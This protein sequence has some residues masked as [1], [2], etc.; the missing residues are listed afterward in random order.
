MSSPNEQRRFQVREIAE[1]QPFTDPAVRSFFHEWCK[2]NDSIRPKIVYRTEWENRKRR[3]T[4]LQRKPGG[5]HLL[6]LPDDLQLWEMIIIIETIDQNTFR[7]DPEKQNVATKEIETLG[8]MFRNAGIYIAQRLDAIENGQEIAEALAI[9]FYQYGRSLSDRKKPE[10]EAPLEEIASQTLSAEET[11]KV[12]RFLAGDSLYAARRKNVEKEVTIDPT[13]ADTLYE[14]VRRKTL[15]QFFRVSA[16]AFELNHRTIKESLKKRVM[17]AMKELRC[18]LTNLHQDPVGFLLSLDEESRLYMNEKTKNLAWEEYQS[19]YRKSDLT[20]QELARRAEL[21]QI[22]FPTKPWETPDS[23]H[24]SFLK[25][26]ER[27]IR[28]KVETPVRELDSSIF[29]RGLELIR[30][31]MPLNVAS[32]EKRGLSHRWRS[33]EKKLRKALQIE[34][35]ATELQEVRASGDI[36]RISNKE[37][38]ITDRI[39]S[40]V[41]KFPYEEASDAVTDIIVRQQMN[42]LGATILGGTLMREVGL[43]YLI[44]APPEHVLLLLLRSDG[45]VEWRDMVDTVHNATLTDDMLDGH[46]KEG[47]RLG[48]RDIVDFYMNPTPDG[49]IFRIKDDRC[50]KSISWVWEHGP[51]YFAVQGQEYGEQIH[52]LDNMGCEF[53]DLN[54]AEEALEILKRANALQPKEEGIYHN[55][56][57]Q[58]HDL[59]RTQESIEMCREGIRAIGQS[60]GLHELLGSNFYELG[61]IDL[62][63]EAYRRAILIDPE[64]LD[65]YYGLGEALAH[66]HHK[67][68]AIKAYTTFVHLAEPIAKTSEDRKRIEEVVALIKALKEDTNKRPIRIQI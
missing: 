25:K 50:P 63:I 5:M 13:N 33:G 56:A 27:K 16:K 39:Q 61:K 42:C 6:F 24:R 52:T 22:V 43:P 7:E 37:H 30:T 54:R 46:T 48:I 62:A 21:E 66:I 49:L 44:A 53:H 34:R 20:E 8:R 45:G 26:T 17:R 38:E 18:L 14:A 51:K 2:R 36:A 11:E 57:V 40:S 3:N 19:L 68:E 9:E 47:S 15:A 1:Q 60:S 28:Q 58:L 67:K 23:T 41:A 35:L 29:R 64:E 12:D 32:K 31:K 4:I 65:S 59:G 10:A 55:L